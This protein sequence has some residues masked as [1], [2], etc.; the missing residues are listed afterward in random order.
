MFSQRMTEHLPASLAGNNKTCQHAQH[1][2]FSR[3]V[4]SHKPDN[5]SPFRLKRSIGENNSIPV[6]NAHV[7]Q[8]NRR[9]TTDDRRGG[10]HLSTTSSLYRPNTFKTIYLQ[11]R[12]CEASRSP[13]KPSFVDKKQHTIEMAD[14]TASIDSKLAQLLI[15]YVPAATSEATAIYP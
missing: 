12:V 1:R 2:A 15:G 4:G 7:S 11:F 8:G 10:P 13:V 14:R 3:A 6:R 9:S 5:V